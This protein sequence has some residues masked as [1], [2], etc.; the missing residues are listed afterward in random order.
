MTFLLPQP[1][2]QSMTL[3]PGGLSQSGSAQGLHSQGSL[4]D[5]IGAGLPPSS[6]MQAQIGNGKQPWR[7]RLALV[8]GN[9][10]VTAWAP[11][12][13][14]LRWRPPLPRGPAAGIH[15]RV[16]QGG[17]GP[18]FQPQIGY[19]PAN[20]RASPGHLSAQVSCSWV[21]SL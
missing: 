9:N 1:P 6:L 17:V 15:M 13:L 10:R 20:Q 18:L 12:W 7:G 19:D 5:A 4:S 16:P 8:P 14:L 11:E 3:G 21:E 2:T